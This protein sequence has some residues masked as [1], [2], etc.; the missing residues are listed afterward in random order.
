MRGGRDCSL[1]S[2]RIFSPG[3]EN[4]LGGGRKDH[5]TLAKGGEK[6]DY[7]VVAKCNMAVDY[8]RGG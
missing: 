2:A 6:T 1:P 3:G 4:I 8:I 7:K 5:G